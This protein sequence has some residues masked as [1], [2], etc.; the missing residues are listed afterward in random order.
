M[1]TAERRQLILSKLDRDRRVVAAE[2]SAELAVSQDTIRRDLRELAAAGK[3]Q[4]VHGGALLPTTTPLDHRER[5]QRASEGKRRIARRAA[6]MIPS[7]QVVFFDSGT[8]TLQ[9]AEHLDPSLRARVVTNSLPVGARLADHPGLEVSLIG[10]QL[11]KNLLATGG[12]AAADSLRFVRADLCV[13]GTAGLHPELGASVLDPEDAYRK[14]L[15]V[16]G[17]A[18]VLLVADQEKLGTSA[19]FLVCSLDAITRLVTDAEPDDDRLSAYRSLGIE[20]ICA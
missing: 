3:A 13:L 1:L 12:S 5:E 6:Q 18:E 2:L 7:G 11:D 17:S 4:R 19:P 9:V 10:G 16:E 14:R 20:I 15:M 8:T